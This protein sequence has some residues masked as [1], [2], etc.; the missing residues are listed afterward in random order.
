MVEAVVR[1]PESV[2]SR[3]ATVAGVVGLVAWAPAEAER[4]RGPSGA[5]TAAVGRC[6]MQDAARRPSGALG[7][8]SVRLRPYARKAALR[9]AAPRKVLT[10]PDMAAPGGH[11]SE[12]APG[13]A[14]SDRDGHHAAVVARERAT[15]VATRPYEAVSGAK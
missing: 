6:S 7:R 8:G 10:K 11:Q 9:G 15:N 1:E 2:P 14:G 4:L 3:I 13:G 12:V 5:A